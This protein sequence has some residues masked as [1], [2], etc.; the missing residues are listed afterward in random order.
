MSIKSTAKNQ[1]KFKKKTNKTNK[2]SILCVIYTYND[3]Y[4]IFNPPPQ[5]LYF[6][7]ISTM[8]REIIL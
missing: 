4:D 6:S 5:L 7:N 3:A 2:K 1:L 8:Y